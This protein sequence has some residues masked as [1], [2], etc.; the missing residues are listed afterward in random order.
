[1]WFATQDIL[2]MSVIYFT[3]FTFNSILLWYYMKLG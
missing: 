1:M 2:E 3:N